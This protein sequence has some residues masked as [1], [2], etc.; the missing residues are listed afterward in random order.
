MRC[1]PA[2]G[3]PVSGRSSCSPTQ[4]AAASSSSRGYSIASEE[5]VSMLAT[6]RIGELSNCTPV[7]IWP[8]VGVTM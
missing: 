6:A 8:T 3:V 7:M 4:P 2:F 1:M 5:M